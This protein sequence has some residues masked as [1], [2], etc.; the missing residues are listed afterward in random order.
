MSEQAAGSGGQT[1]CPTSSEDAAPRAVPWRCSDVCWGWLCRSGGP[2]ARWGGAGRDGLE[3]RR[4]RTGP[5]EAC[6]S[7]GVP[8]V[9]LGSSGCERLYHKAASLSRNFCRHFNP[10]LSANQ[11]KHGPNLLMSYGQ[12]GAQEREIHSTNHPE[13]SSKPCGSGHRLCSLGQNLQCSV[14]ESFVGTSRR[15]GP[16][17]CG[18]VSRWMGC[19]STPLRLVSHVPAP[20]KALPGGYS[21]G[22]KGNS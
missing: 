10:N 3:S 5:G 16:H 8:G 4:G 11:S 21:S 9:S 12:D 7:L 13:V 14:L 1:A 18:D 22:D 17:S 6:T 19:P 20:G 15:P 2:A